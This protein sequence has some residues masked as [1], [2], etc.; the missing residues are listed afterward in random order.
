M[1]S[2]G[3]SEC[4]A[5]LKW[6]PADRPT[7][8]HLSTSRA[9]LEQKGQEVPFFPA[10]DPPPNPAWQTPKA[11]LQHSQRGK[12]EQK[13]MR[14]ATSMNVNHLGSQDEVAFRNSA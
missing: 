14:R 12:L 3:V 4:T 5:V 7:G 8:R 10:T 2:L 9:F 6:T 11:E 1:A 13:Q